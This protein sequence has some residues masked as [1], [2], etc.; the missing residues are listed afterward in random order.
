MNRIIKKHKSVSLGIGVGAASIHRVYIEALIAATTLLQL[1]QIPL[2]APLYG[3]IAPGTNGLVPL[4]AQLAHALSIILHTVL[5]Q[6]ELP[7]LAEEQARC[8]GLAQV[9]GLDF[10][11]SNLCDAADVRRVEVGVRALVAVWVNYLNAVCGQNW[12]A[13]VGWLDQVVATLTLLTESIFLLCTVRVHASVILQFEPSKTHLALAGRP[14]N[15]AVDILTQPIP[16]QMQSL[17][18]YQAPEP[19][20]VVLSASVQLPDTLAARGQNVVWPAL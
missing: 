1:T 11:A 3:P 8:T 14:Y 12:P 5:S 7:V 2:H 6:A 17:F 16:R 15:L 13:Q 10:A 20:L 19:L 4:R 9:F 18:A